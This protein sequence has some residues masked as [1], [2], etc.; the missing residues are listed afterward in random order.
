MD[1]ITAVENFLREVP[2]FYLTTLNGTRPRCRPIGFHLLKDGKIYFGVGTFKEVYQ[3]MQDSPYVEICACKGGQFLRYYGEAVF[4]TDNVIA[5]SVLE[6]S[7]S[8]KKIY[9][10]ETGY[11]LGIFHLENALAE[12]HEMSKLKETYSF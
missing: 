12:F 6:S 5:D 11:K 9:N 2:V 10:Q 8:L 1:K 3:Q 7:P 4:G